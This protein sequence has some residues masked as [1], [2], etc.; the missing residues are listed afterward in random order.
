MGEAS[1]TKAASN[2]T[3]AKSMGP[4]PTNAQ[5]YLASATRKGFAEN[6]ISA[7]TRGELTVLSLRGISEHLTVL[8]M[9]YQKATEVLQRQSVKSVLKQWMKEGLS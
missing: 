7:S 2:A 6:I 4:K 9:K 8:P 1:A 5:S 3:N